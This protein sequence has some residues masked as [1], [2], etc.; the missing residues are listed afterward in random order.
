VLGA[1]VTLYNL[2]THSKFSDSL[3]VLLHLFVG[4]S[5]G[6]RGHDL[7]IY[8]PMVLLSQALVVLF[9]SLSIFVAFSYRQFSSLRLSKHDLEP[10]ANFGGKL[11]GLVSIA[12][13]L[14]VL[15]QVTIGVREIKV[16]LCDWQVIF[17][18]QSRII[19]TVQS[20]LQIFDTGGD[21]AHSVSQVSQVVVYLVEKTPFSNE[22]LRHF[23]LKDFFAA[24]QHF[25][26]SLELLSVHQLLCSLSAL[27]HVALQNILQL[28]IWI[29]HFYILNLLQQ[30]CRRKN[31]VNY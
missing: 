4:L 15:L 10:V 13:T 5:H 22:V 29:V 27:T 16:S 8:L 31:N 3:I 11:V 20:S 26:S 12:H 7:E 18:G 19:G 6:K 24:S 1:E 21:I 23:L 25:L 9:V 14:V 28:P 17:T 2:T 30:F